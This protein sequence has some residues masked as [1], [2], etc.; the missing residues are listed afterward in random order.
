MVDE[1]ILCCNPGTRISPTDVH[2]LKLQF[3]PLFLFLPGAA[4][5]PPGLQSRQYHL[6]FGA[7]VNPAHSK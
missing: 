7:A 6:P 1:L 5:F 2:K 4:A 3:I